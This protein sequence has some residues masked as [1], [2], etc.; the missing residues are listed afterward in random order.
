MTYPLTGLQQAIYALLSADTT[1]AVLVSA[2]YDQPPD[3]ANYPF[4]AIEDWQARDWSFHAVAGVE[5]ELLLGVYS[6]YHGKK[7]ALDIMARL[8][9][10][11]QD[12]TLSASGINIVQCR[13]L[14]SRV[15]LLGDGRSERGSMRFRL[16]AHGS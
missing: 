5:A 11:L 14:D 9:T 2:V 8:H 4:V 13:L 10:L 7:Q 16:L 6:R 12:A 3:T 15:V 1:L